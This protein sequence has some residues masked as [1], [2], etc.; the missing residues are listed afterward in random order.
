M[1]PPEDSTQE[2]ELDVEADSSDEVEE[3][4]HE[5]PEHAAPA[6]GDLDPALEKELRAVLVE[7][8]EAPKNPGQKQLPSR[9]ID[10]PLRPDDLFDD[11]SI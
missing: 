7:E 5:E 10:E 9:L 11:G 2:P 3:T 1:L 4:G 6:A 8:E